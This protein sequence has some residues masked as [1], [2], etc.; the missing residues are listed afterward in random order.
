MEQDYSRWFVK[1]RVDLEGMTVAFP[2]MISS[3]LY[4]SQMDYFGFS[5]LCIVREANEAESYMVLHMPGKVI[6]Y[7][8]NDKTFDKII[9]FGSGHE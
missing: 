7:N 6:R 3:I 4:P 5:I 9:D 8:F 1:Y 2:E